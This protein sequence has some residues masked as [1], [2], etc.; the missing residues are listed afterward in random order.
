MSQRHDSPIH[1]QRINSRVGA[2]LFGLSFAA[3][4]L[5]LMV[6]R[7][8]PAVV[9]YVAYYSNLMLISSFLGLGIGAMMARRR[10]QLFWLFPTLL[11]LDIGVM[12]QTHRAIVVMPMSQ[13]E[14]R[15]NFDVMPL[16]SYVVLI[17]VFVLNTIVFVPLGQRIG[18][19]FL[20]LAPLQAYACD[21]GGSLCGTLAFGLF[22]FYR[23][24]PA[25]GM[26]VIA[27]LF[28]ILAGARQKIWNLPILV[29]IVLSVPL[30]TD[31]AAIWSPYHYLT[32]NPYNSF[33]SAPPPPAD[34][35][36]MIDPPIYH[37]RVNT[38]LYQ[39]DGTIDIHRYSPGG[40]FTDYVGQVLDPQYFFPYQ[41]KHSPQKVCVLGSGGGLDVEAALLS[42]AASVDAVDIDPI[43]VQLSRQYNAA[44]P[45]DDPRV[46]VRVT[47]ARAFIQATTSQYDLIVFG[48]IDSHALFSSS[49]NVRLDGFIYTV[50]SIRRAY[51]LL[52]PDGMLCI[53]F[54]VPE[55]APWLGNKLKAM[56]Q[57]ATGTVP[58]AYKKDVVNIF[59]APRNASSLSIAPPAEQGGFV[60]DASPAQPVDLPTDDWPFLYLSHRVIPNDY[61]IVIGSLLILSIGT[62]LALRFTEKAG[63]ARIGAAEGHFFFMGLGFLLLETKSIGDCSLYFGTTWLVTMI[64]VTGVLIMVLAANLVAMRIARASLSQ[65]GPLL[66]MLILLYFVP[67]DVV[68]GLPLAVRLLFAIFI[69]PLPIF[70]AGLIFSTTFRDGADPATLLG[71]NLIGA[72]IGG[73]LEYLAMAVGMHALTIL[74]IGAY[75]ASL[76]CQR[77]AMRQ[78]FRA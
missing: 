34:L 23:F 20:Q 35:R 42:G 68:L 18:A 15:F 66:A 75:V 77:K 22:S 72:T 10:M 46:N 52:K 28:L 39:Q 64:V 16:M 41:L 63:I 36:T 9:H 27:A 67:R 25:V 17:G 49:N 32:I 37:V 73:F 70:F 38:D 14:A 6:I 5:E 33:E 51:Q 13:S 24:S 48:L 71:A 50:E 21:L 12:I 2:Q 29:A 65:Y 7:W 26:G 4:F 55:P 43:L 56:I 59:C 53:S 1:N 19:L 54:L 58:L 11:A 60:R 57:E 3:L 61:L 76:L 44:D 8:A 47:D 78:T 31:P 69:V 62:V 40:P 74:V 30:S 45:Y